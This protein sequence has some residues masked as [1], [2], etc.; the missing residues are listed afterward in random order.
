MCQA[1]K[2]VKDA[3]HWIA[4]LIVWTALALKLDF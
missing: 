4:S 2:F 3:V 1:L